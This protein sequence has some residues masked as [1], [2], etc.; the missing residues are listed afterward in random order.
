[1]L[2]LDAVIVFVQK[3]HD[4]GAHELHVEV[5]VIDHEQHGQ[6][7][8]HKNDPCGSTG[9]GQPR[10]TSNGSHIQRNHQQIM[11]FFLTDS[12]E[13]NH[14]KDSTSTIQS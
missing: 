14:E 2:A 7:G 4:D 9:R 6:R 12:E 11:I 13:K 5:I 3:R 1:M 10:S 8:T